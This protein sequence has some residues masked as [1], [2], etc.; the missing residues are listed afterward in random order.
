MKYTSK[1]HFLEELSKSIESDLEKASGVKITD[2][3][4]KLAGIL[5]GYESEGNA[6][7]NHHDIAST[8]SHNEAKHIV[9]THGADEDHEK[10]HTIQT[11]S[12]AYHKAI[13]SEKQ[14]PS[15]P[16]T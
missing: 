13:G 6:Q 2:H 14:K 11:V 16:I 15:K 12:N 1:E 5:N 9:D 8:F 7:F 4:R 10:N 3:H